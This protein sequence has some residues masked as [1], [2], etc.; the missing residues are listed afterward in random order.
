MP[1]GSLVKRSVL[2]LGLLMPLMLYGVGIWRRPSRQVV[3]RQP[4]F[5]GIVYSRHIADHPRPQVAHVVEIDL[6]TPGLIPYVTPAYQ[7]VAEIDPLDWERR[8]TIARRTSE[9][10]KAEGLQ[11]AINANYFFPFRE[12]TLWN[13]QPRSGQLASLVGLAI[14]NGNKTSAEDPQRA[15]I[16]FLNQQATIRGDSACP[17]E[18]QQAV[19]GNW[20]L[21]NQGQPTETVQQ[22]LPNEDNK[23]YSYTIAALDATGTRLWLVLIDGKQPLY[24]EGMTLAEVTRFVQAL[25]A[26]TALQLD[27]GGSTT[28]AIAAATGPQVLNAPIHAKVPGQERPVANHLGFFAQP[29][30][31][32]IDNN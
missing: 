9:A 26:D 22:Q 3:T 31:P 12:V 23:P 20:M 14:A 8:E 17:Q 29:L 5:R 1:R 13:Y 24:S 21:L 18:T 10:I 2:W 16:C 19:A 25:G 27:G 32:E 28:I 6:T 30:D 7:P 15:A 11:L 4:L